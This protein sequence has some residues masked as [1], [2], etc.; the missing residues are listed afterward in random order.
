MDKQTEVTELVELADIEEY[1]RAGKPVP[2]AKRYQYR[3]NKARFISETPTLTREDILKRAGLP[4]DLYRLRLKQHKG[5]PREIKPH[6]VVDLRAPGVERFIATKKEVQDGRGT[7][8]DFV[9]SP[10]DVEFLDGLD[11]EWEAV[12][13]GGAMWVLIY[14]VPLPG[15]FNEPRVDVAI[16]ITAGYPTAALDMAYFHPPIRHADGRAIPQTESMQSLDSKQWQRWSR[17][18]TG[19][20]PWVP[21]EDNLERHFGFMLDWFQ[22]ELER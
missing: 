6:E 4:E 18:R 22:R 7:R 13:E 11:L 10:E 20:N 1:A 17:H 2:A 14:G 8:R 3:V 19:G 15:G 16:Q 21:G 9:L 5:P 12:C